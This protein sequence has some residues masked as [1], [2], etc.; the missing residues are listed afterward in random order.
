MIEQEFE[1]DDAKAAKVFRERGID[2]N[3]MIEISRCRGSNFLRTKKV[4][5]ERLLS[6]N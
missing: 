6:E 1:W 5:Q 3:D 2:F 4:N